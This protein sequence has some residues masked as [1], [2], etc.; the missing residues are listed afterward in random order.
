[1][2]SLD[3]LPIDGTTSASPA[4]MNVLKKYFGNKKQNSKLWAELKLVLFATVLFMVLSTT[5]FDRC[6]D[7][8][9]YVENPLMK[10]GLRALIYA[11]ALYVIMIMIGN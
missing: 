9:P 3:D 11:T 4:E 6:L 1:M 2:D 5:F 8:L 10:L 7:N